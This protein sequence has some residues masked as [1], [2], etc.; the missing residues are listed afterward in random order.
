MRR[1]RSGTRSAP[2]RRSI[3][4]TL[5]KASTLSTSRL[6]PTRSTSFWRTLVSPP[7]RPSRGSSK[8]LSARSSPFSTR[9]TPWMPSQQASPSISTIRRGSCSCCC[10]RRVPKRPSRTTS[11]SSPDRRFCQLCSRCQRCARA[12]RTSFSSSLSAAATRCE[13]KTARL[14]RRMRWELWRE[15]MVLMK[16]LLAARLAMRRR[17]ADSIRRG[18]REESFGRCGRR[19]ALRGVRL[20]MTSNSGGSRSRSRS[21]RRVGRRRLR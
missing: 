4:T 9:R 21:T 10:P 14:T 2:I 15:L 12:S 11:S 16:K 3:S 8:R 20:W 18:N 6:A 13:A 17:R 19:L 5:T 1:R 7:S